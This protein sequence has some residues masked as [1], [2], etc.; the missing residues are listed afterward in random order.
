M[1][2]TEVNGLR[3]LDTLTG[4]PDLDGFVGVG[5]L[6]VDRHEDTHAVFF[7]LPLDTASTFIK[8]VDHY[9]IE[10]VIR[11]EVFE[12]EFPPGAVQTQTRELLRIR[13][14]IAVWWPVVK[15]IE[16]G[17]SRPDTK[18]FSIKSIPSRTGDQK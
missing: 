12:V 14:P 15:R 3:V 6:V 4:P 17:K 16:F 1:S 7:W 9:G 10:Y 18:D 13:L 5:L 2:I 8:H 11:D